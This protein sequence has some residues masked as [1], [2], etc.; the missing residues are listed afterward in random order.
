MSIDQEISSTTSSRIRKFEFL[1]VG[2][3]LAVF[4][5]FS[6]MA[7]KP[8]APSGDTLIHYGFGEQILGATFQEPIQFARHGTSPFTAAFVIACKAREALNPLLGPPSDRYQYPGLDIY[9]T[10]IFWSYVPVLFLALAGM[11]VFWLY[12][13]KTLGAVA[14]LSAIMLMAL[15]PNYMAHSHFATTDMASTFGFLLGAIVLGWYLYNPGW[16]R[17]I[18]LA[19]ILGFAQVLKI[20][21][22][23]LYPAAG[24]IVCLFEW[25]NP[26]RQPGRAGIIE[27][28]R[29]H[30]LTF[31]VLF[32][33]GFI[34]M[35]QL[36]YALFINHSS[37]NLM[38]SQSPFKELQ[39]PYGGIWF[40]LNPIIPGLYSFTLAY[41][42]YFNSL[43]NWSF[44]AG[45][46]REYGWWYYYPVAMSLKTPLPVLV[47]GLLGFGL[48]CRLAIRK[49]SALTPLVIPALLYLFYFCFFV[50]ANAGVRHVLPIYPAMYALGGFALAWLSARLAPPRKWIPQTVTAVWLLIVSLITFP[51]YEEYFNVIAGGSNNGWKW[52]GDSNIDFGQDQFY[53]E[54]WAK[55]QTVP[56]S[57][58][59]ME[60]VTGRVII[61]APLLIGHTRE[62]TS[63]TAW[64]RQ[65]KVV[66]QPTPAL[67]VFDVPTE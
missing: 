11:A 44:L 43:P 21:N 61:R 38:I 10:S 17:G 4:A 65:Y 14:A 60:P 8:K 50:H 24:L 15:E 57:F 52:L 1:S 16:K 3:I 39:E 40:K 30:A 67:L 36:G 35:L 27:S 41:A 48:W 46:Y 23:L 54:D 26:M 32:P 2:I 47:L 49:W 64:L 56:V 5:I 20:P 7:A 6:I 9:L 63:N 62:M 22:I 19:L 55:K 18:A 53:V 45:E 51:H 13:R 42:K 33:L 37:F 28:I 66:E 59:P 29:R 34:I 25:Q 12:V 58:D 31:V